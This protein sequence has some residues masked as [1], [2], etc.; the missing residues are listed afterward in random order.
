M[1]DKIFKYK[2]EYTLFDGRVG[3]EEHYFSYLPVDKTF[4]NIIKEKKKDGFV[5][6]DEDGSMRKIRGSSI[7]EGRVANFE[8]LKDEEEEDE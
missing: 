6:R 2:I 4:D 8:V 1:D 3:Y 5:I 7:K